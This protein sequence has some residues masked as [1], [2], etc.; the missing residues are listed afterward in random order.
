MLRC[1]CTAVCALLCVGLNRLQAVAY[2]ST[3]TYRAND[4]GAGDGSIN[5]SPGSSAGAG[6]G[7]GSK[8]VL[9]G[10][11]ER[12]HLLFDPVTAEPTHLCTG[13]CLNDNYTKCNDN[14]WPGY[15]DRTF[16]SVQPIQQRK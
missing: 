10:K 9:Y 4:S 15:A 2:S 7:A 14:P 1:V 8:E 16:T 5:D 11:R 12:P 13:V 6:A 3:V